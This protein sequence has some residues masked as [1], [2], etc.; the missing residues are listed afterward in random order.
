MAGKTM[1]RFYCHIIFVCIEA[2]SVVLRFCSHTFSSLVSFFRIFFFNS[3]V[4]EKFSQIVKLW[5]FFCQGRCFFHLY[6]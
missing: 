4:L 2:Q 1:V 3:R 6:I 5:L